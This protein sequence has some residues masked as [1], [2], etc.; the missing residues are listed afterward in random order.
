MSFHEQHEPL[1]SKERLYFDPS[2]LT[3]EQGAALGSFD[4]V[5]ENI[6]KSN[7]VFAE[8]LSRF[9]PIVSCY[10]DAYR[11]YEQAGNPH[12]H[13]SIPATSFESAM[14]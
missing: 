10:R 2:S 3:S 1:S 14:Q 6:T 4:A 5:L 13:A 9:S 12:S 11:K 8:E 7:S